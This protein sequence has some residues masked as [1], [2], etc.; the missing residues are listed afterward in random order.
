MEQIETI[1]IKHVSHGFLTGKIM[2]PVLADINLSVLSG[3]LT[4]IIGPSGSGK[5]T[6]LAT[7][8]GLLRP[9]HGH[10]CIFNQNIMSLNDRALEQFRFKHCGFVFQG[11]NLFNSLTALENVLLP[12][13][14]GYPIEREEAEQRAYN[15]LKIV[16]MANKQTMRPI[17]L[18]GGEKQRVAIARAL[19]KNPPLLFADEPTSA[20]DK[21][22]GQNIIDILRTIAHKRNATV[23]AV[24]HD[25]RLISHADRIITIED[26]RIKHDVSKNKTKTE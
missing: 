10:I 24:S 9:N 26:G 3:E 15:A 2:Q 16:G 23:V 20:L 4:L 13:N 5:S 25:H 17:E 12:L 7:I 1:N 21:V 19:I 6:L 18:S 22:S 8:S 11:Y 14:Y